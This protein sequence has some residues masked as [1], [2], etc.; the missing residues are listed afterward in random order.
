MNIVT[1]CPD[2]L[3]GTLSQHNDISGLWYFGRPEVCA[4]VTYHTTH[5][6]GRSWCVNEDDVDWT[7]PKQGQGD[8]YLLRATQRKTI[9]LP[10]TRVAEYAE[11]E[12]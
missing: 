2:T 11:I 8:Y 1:G 10:T 4:A 5:T 7:N 6:L 9:W 12:Q 3:V